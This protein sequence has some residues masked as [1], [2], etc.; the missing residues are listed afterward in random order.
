MS[1]IRFITI[2]SDLYDGEICYATFLDNS[3]NTINLGQKFFHF[4][5]KQVAKLELVLFMSLPLTIHSLLIYPMTY[6]QHQHQPPHQ[7]KLKHQHK[8]QLQLIQRHKHQQKHQ[9]IHLQK[10]KRKHLLILKH[11]PIH[12]LKHQ[13]PHQLKLQAKLQV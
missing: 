13:P 2:S 12:Q 9:Q 11:Q 4:S 10:L 1:Q 7:H 8:H 5:L 3:G 6:V